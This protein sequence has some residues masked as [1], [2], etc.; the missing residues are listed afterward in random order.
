MIG[1]NISVNG[2]DSLI[3]TFRSFSTQAD[4]LLQDALLDSVNKNIVV[5]AKTLAPKKTGALEQSISVQR[6][7][8][9]TSVLLVADKPYAGFLEYGTKYIPEGK[10]SFLRPAS[11]IGKGAVVEDLAALF[12]EN[13]S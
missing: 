2:L 8:T 1:V 7:E 6:R 5:V 3:E 9:P 4:Q 11:A 12:E 13:L 10:F